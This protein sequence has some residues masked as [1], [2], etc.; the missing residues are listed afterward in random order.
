MHSNGGSA[1]G[2]T[3]FYCAPGGQ[4]LTGLELL[5]LP[6]KTGT[7]LGLS[8]LLGFLIAAVLTLISLMIIS[9]RSRAHTA[10]E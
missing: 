3:H 4:P 5:S 10:R 7:V 6:E 2:A 1:Q 9:L 8:F